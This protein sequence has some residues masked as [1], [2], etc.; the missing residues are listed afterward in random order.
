MKKYII[1]IVYIF[2]FE[3]IHPSSILTYLKQYW[4]ISITTYNCHFYLTANHTNDLQ[5]IQRLGN[6]KYM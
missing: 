2:L 5:S 6:N 1:L 3:V 4:L